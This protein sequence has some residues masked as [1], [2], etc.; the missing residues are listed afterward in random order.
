MN[1]VKNKISEIAK[2]LQRNRIILFFVSL[3][4]KIMPQFIYQYISGPLFILFVI[5]FIFSIIMSFLMI[6]VLFFLHKDDSNK[7]MN[8]DFNN[9]IKSDL[10]EIKTNLE[11]AIENSDSKEFI[12]EQLTSDD[13]ISG[14]YGDYFRISFKTL[15]DNQYENFYFKSG[16]YHERTFEDN[17]IESVNKFKQKVMKNSEYK[18][19]K[20]FIKGMSDNLSPNFVSPFKDTFDC[21]KE[22]IKNIAYYPKNDSMGDTYSSIMK[23]YSISSTYNNV[24]LHFLRARFMQ[25]KL[26]SLF[27]NT[28][29]EVIEGD[30]ATTIDPKKRSAMMILYIP[31]QN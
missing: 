13:I 14:L 27:P 6:L 20:I 30:T 28:P 19:T 15:K 5:I 21:Q 31:K 18:N 4:K 23:T 29:I 11:V 22:D 10:V 12:V 1:C 7:N 16:M 25:C 8:V 9:H 3:F 2:K 24:D 17:L 26:K